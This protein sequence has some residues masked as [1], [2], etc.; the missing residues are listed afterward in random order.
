MQKYNGDLSRFAEPLIER[1]DKSE[2]I[3]AMILLL[4]LGVTGA[5]Q[6]ARGRNSIGLCQLALF[7]LGVVYTGFVVSSLSGVIFA[8]IL[9]IWLLADLGAILTELMS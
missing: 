9:V 8:A 1:E 4:L 2:T 5:H 7:C 6:F 3:K